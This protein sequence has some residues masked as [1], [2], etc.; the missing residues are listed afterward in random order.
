MQ[1]ISNEGDDPR[2]AS[3]V[4]QHLGAALRLSF[5][6]PLTE[7]LPSKLAFWL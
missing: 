2:D 3:L 7:P 5:E 1:P 4:L 6:S